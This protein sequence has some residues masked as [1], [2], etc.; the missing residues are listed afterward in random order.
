MV[1]ERWLA[2]VEMLRELPRGH[3][4]RTQ[5]LEDTTP[6]GVGECLESFSCHH[7]SLSSIGLRYSSYQI[8]RRLSKY[9]KYGSLKTSWKPESRF[10]GAT[11]MSRN[12][13]FQ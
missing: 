10:F 4:P 5:Q 9:L 1:T 7:R 3:I 13:A 8:F 2:D 12:G 11:L 6:R